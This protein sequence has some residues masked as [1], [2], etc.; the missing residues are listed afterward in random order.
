MNTTLLQHFCNTS[1][2]RINYGP[3][4]SPQIQTLGPPSAHYN[5]VC[6]APH[7]QLQF[8]LGVRKTLS[9]V[10]KIIVLDSQTPSGQDRP[11]LVNILAMFMLTSTT[12]IVWGIARGLEA[13]AREEDMLCTPNK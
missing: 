8:L 9:T 2:C 11:V 7:M 13:S 4:T 3:P 12:S 10:C 5:C 6:I 1:V